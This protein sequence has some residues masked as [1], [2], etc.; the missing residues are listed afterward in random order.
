MIFQRNEDGSI[1]VD[2]GTFAEEMDIAVHLLGQADP[3]MLE[4][5][6]RIRT[7]EG[8]AIYLVT[9]ADPL[10]SPTLHGRLVRVE[11]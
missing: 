2:G 10:G 5:T 6:I 11:S 3:E 1:S 8:T 7:R 9:G 4:T